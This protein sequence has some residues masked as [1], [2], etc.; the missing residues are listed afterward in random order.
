MNN[1]DI[2]NEIYHQGENITDWALQQ[3]R[4]HYGDEKISTWDIFYYVY[5][6]LH[7]PEYR[8]RFAENLKRELPRIPFMSEFKPFAE[9]GKKL[10]ELHLQY[11]TVA[12]YKLAYEWAAGKPVSYRVEKMRLN[13]DKS[14]LTVNNA[15]TLRGIPA[16]AFE[17]RLGN[18]SALDWVIDQYQVKTDSKSGMGSDP[19][20]WSEDEK[21]IVELV[22]RVVAVSVQTVAIVKTLAGYPLG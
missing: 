19:N 3:F 8:S 7:H 6:V 15:L 20:G 18:R 2:L 13:K 21:Y 10:A 9:A 1:L 4:Q 14:A 5:A 22:G 11:E 16:E 17:Y 12:P